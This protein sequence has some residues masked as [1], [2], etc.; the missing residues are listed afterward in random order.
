MCLYFVDQLD[1]TV[2]ITH[3]TYPTLQLPLCDMLLFEKG[4][5]GMAVT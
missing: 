5:S 1:R 4:G 3:C 2:F